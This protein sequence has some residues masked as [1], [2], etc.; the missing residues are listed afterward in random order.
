MGLGN[1]DPK[2]FQ[3]RHN[4]GHS[5][6]QRLSQRWSIA[7]KEDLCHAQV[8]QG[9]LGKQEV[10]LVLSQRFMN[11]SGQVVEC[12]LKRWGIPAENF[13]GGL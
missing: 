1:P 6:L 13:F 11:S 7:L 9:K 10:A 8:G 4:V 3:T 12:L 2:Y 5:L